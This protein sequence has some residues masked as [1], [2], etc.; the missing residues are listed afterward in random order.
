MNSDDQERTRATLALAL[1]SLIWGYNWV[2]MKI[3]LSF[4]G[5]FDFSALRFVLGA[6]CLLPFMY[7]SRQPILPVRD[8]WWPLVILGV[9]LAANFGLTMTALKWSGVGRI[10]VIVYTMPFWVLM[11][12]RIALD[13]KLSR[14]QVLAVCVAAAGLIVLVAPWQL[15][16]AALAGLMA[17]AAGAS[18]GASVVFVKTLQK[19][20]ATGSMLIAFWQMV[21]AAPLLGAVGWAVDSQPVDWSAGL[22]LTVAYVGILATGVAWMLFYYALRRLTAGMAGLGTLATPVIGAFAAWLH[23]GERPAPLE[24]IGMA[25]IVLALAI[26]SLPSLRRP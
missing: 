24:F 19:R 22:L 15:G 6:A 23:L 9:M 2:V 17:V 21:I 12:A 20:H 8:Q 16:G 4:A 13:E 14:V 26:L 11:F 7:R 25:L 1:L 3:G 10:A 18:W 5:P